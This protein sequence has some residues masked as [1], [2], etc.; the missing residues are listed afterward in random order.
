MDKERFINFGYYWDATAELFG[1]LRWS[2]KRDDLEMARVSLN[3]LAALLARLRM[4]LEI[5]YGRLREPGLGAQAE[6]PDWA[7]YSPH[8]ILDDMRNAAA[9]QGHFIDQRTMELPAAVG[10]EKADLERR[11][12]EMGDYLHRFIRHGRSTFLEKWPGWWSPQRIKEFSD[13]LEPEERT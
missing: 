6:L 9:I 13:Y 4:D 12:A 3:G 1:G 7:D 5:K 10:E 11:I 2:L 8:E